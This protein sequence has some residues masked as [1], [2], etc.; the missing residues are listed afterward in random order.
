MLILFSL[1]N[2]QYFYKAKKELTNEIDYST[3]VL[4][5]A[6]KIEFLKKSF[7]PII[8][9]FCKKEENEKI[10]LICNNLNSY[11]L[12][13]LN[14]VFQKSKISSFDLEKNK[15]INLYLELYR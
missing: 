2:F 7:K 13:Y 3:K 6:K 4:T 1:L 14:S 8:P 11:K 10:F 15:S 5:T 9:N 12:N